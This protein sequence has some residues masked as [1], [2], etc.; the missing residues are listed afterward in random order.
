MTPARWEKLKTRAGRVVEKTIAEL[1]PEVLAEA[2]KVPVLFEE[3]CEDDPD[4]LGTYGHFTPNQIG[5]GNGPIILYLSTIVDFC[6]E[7]GGDFSAEVR[8]TYLH[9]LGHHLGW[10]EDDLAARGLE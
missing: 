3:W 10:D 1:P 9:E 8:L 6:A 2:R 5:E 7:E 4:I